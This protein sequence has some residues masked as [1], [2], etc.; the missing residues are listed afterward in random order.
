MLSF[1]V[2]LKILA[3]LDIKR[4]GFRSLS[5]PESLA[6]LKQLDN[7]LTVLVFCQWYRTTNIVEE[8][9]KQSFT[10]LHV[11]KDFLSSR[12]QKNQDF[13][14]QFRRL[15]KSPELEL[16]HLHLLLRNDCNP[17]KNCPEW[18]S[19]RARKVLKNAS[20]MVVEE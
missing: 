8:L 13:I 16:K 17:Q 15:H 10:V 19:K 20:S 4:N 7:K 6:I 9:E 3:F 1:R 11:E 5:V 18:L 14:K 12:K 2:T